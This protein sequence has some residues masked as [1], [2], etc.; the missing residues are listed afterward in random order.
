MF[1]EIINKRI[2][3]WISANIFI[4]LS[5]ALFPVVNIEWKVDVFCMKL[6]VFAFFSLFCIVSKCSVGVLAE[7]DDNRNVD[8]SHN[9]HKHICKIP[10]HSCTESC[11]NKYEE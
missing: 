10:E 3:I 2:S 6:W 1:D 11:T 9:T 8:D 5:F 7:K 4:V